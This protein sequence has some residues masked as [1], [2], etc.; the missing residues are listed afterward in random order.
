MNRCFY[1]KMAADN[2]KRNKEIYI[3]YL[4][5]SGIM[6]MVYYIFLLIAGNEGMNNIPESLTLKMIMNIGVWVGAVFSVI[7]IF[8]ANSFLIK[9]RKT[10]FGLYGILGLEKRHVAKVMFW[11]TGIAAAASIGGG[12]VAG[13]V[14]AK[15]AFLIL[16]KLIHVAEG[17]RLLINP[18]AI[19]KTV[20]LFFVIFLCAAVFNLLQVHLAKPVALMHSANKGEREPK[21]SVIMTIAA[22]L[23]LGCGYYMALTMKSTMLEYAKCFAAVILVIFGTYGL[24]IAGSIKILRRLKCNKK[25]YYRPDNFVS[26]SGLIYRLRRNAVGLASICIICTMILITMSMT[27]SMQIGGKDSVSKSVGVDLKVSNI[28]T[29]EYES[30][31]VDGL[32][33]LA[34]IHGITVERCDIFPDK[35]FIGYYVGGG[36]FVSAYGGFEHDDEQMM[37]KDSSGAYH[38]IVEEMEYFNIVLISAQN[39]ER[40]SGEAVS[41]EDGHGILVCASEDPWNVDGRARLFGEDIFYF[42]GGLARND[43]LEENKKERVE[44]A[45][46]IDKVVHESSFLDDKYTKD[47]IIYLVLKDDAAVDT[48]DNCY[49]GSDYTIAKIEFSGSDVNRRQFIEALKEPLDATGYAASFNSSDELLESFYIGYGGL[50]FVGVMLSVLFLL[51]MVLI[52]YYKQMSEGIEDRLRYQI[53]LKVGIDE[54][55]VAKTISKQVKTIFFVPL[56]VA[57][58]HT[59]AAFKLTSNILSAVMFRNY[60]LFAACTAGAILVVVTVYVIVYRAT[61]QAYYRRIH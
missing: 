42:F 47:S 12:I 38:E 14:F 19:V 45:V 32:E 43:A 46:S 7:F 27:I 31:L 52:I 13:T 36:Q 57:V 51:A 30:I 49:V 10:E 58:V 39:Y 2:L 6:I 18:T 23:C 37:W 41:L 11:E 4:L 55:D 3:P 21:G 44:T 61:A 16:L 35:R 33:H 20:V 9:Q 22:I 29:K 8:Y 48:L 1:L 5:A 15:L 60:G 25:I 17:S 59:A 53:L 40:L 56:I 54:K 24:F 34:P 26:I 50:V 28:P